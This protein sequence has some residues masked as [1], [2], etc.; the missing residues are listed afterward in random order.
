MTR[1][2]KFDVPAP[3]GVP[4]IAPDDA[5]NDNPTGNVAV[6]RAQVYGGVPPV[7][8]KVVEV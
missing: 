1:I 8:A 6:A 2:V 5:F 4:V 3:V 7:A